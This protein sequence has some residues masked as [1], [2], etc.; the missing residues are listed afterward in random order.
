MSVEWGAVELCVEVS[1]ILLLY[2]DQDDE[3]GAPDDDCPTEWLIETI[4]DGPKD[5]VELL[6]D[7]TNKELLSADD[8]VGLT[9]PRLEVQLLNDVY[10]VPVGPKLVVELEVGYGA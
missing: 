8:V 5:A 9:P 2:L 6:E 3:Y 10:P 1:T 7:V 4:V